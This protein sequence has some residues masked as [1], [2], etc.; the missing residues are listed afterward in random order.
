MG[1]LTWSPFHLADKKTEAQQGEA[2]VFYHVAL[3]PGVAASTLGEGCGQGQSSHHSALAGH[4]DWLRDGHMDRFRP[5]PSS[6]KTCLQS[7]MYSPRA[8]ERL[9]L[10]KICLRV[11]TSQRKLRE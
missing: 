9:L 2:T 8:A 5:N 10:G 11:K 3:W 6:L 1:A 4:H 7:L